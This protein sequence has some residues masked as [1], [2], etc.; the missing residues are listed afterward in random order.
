MPN[1]LIPHT[2]PFLPYPPPSTLTSFTGKLVLSSYWEPTLRAKPKPLL[3][4]IGDAGVL[5]N[6][7]WVQA[8]PP[9]PPRMPPSPASTATAPP[10][11]LASFLG[12]PA[13]DAAGIKPLPKIT[14]PALIGQGLGPLVWLDAASWTSGE[15]LSCCLFSR[16]ESLPNGSQMGG[17]CLSKIG[18]R[19][20]GWIMATTS[21]INNK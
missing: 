6:R 12:P 15:P 21:K 13:T 18:E 2:A 14:L 5:Q 19:K 10:S 7:S 1:P 20:Q 16:D 17:I 8:S 4:S 9:T 11:H 3:S